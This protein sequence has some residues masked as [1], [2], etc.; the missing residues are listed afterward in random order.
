M[1]GDLIDEVSIATVFPASPEVANLYQAHVGDPSAKTDSKHDGASGQVYTWRWALGRRQKALYG[2]VVRKRPTFVAWP[3]LPAILRLVGEL[4]APDEL[5]DIGVISNDAYRIASVL[6]G[7]SEPLSTSAIRQKA[8]F[9]TGKESSQAYHNGLAELESRLVVTS[10]FSP[11]DELGIKHHALMFQRHRG[12]VDAAHAMT[13]EHGVD[14]LLRAYLPA[15]RYLL[16]PVF[17][18]HVRVPESEVVAGLLRLQETGYVQPSPYP[19][20]NAVCF[21]IAD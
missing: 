8:G 19:V 1:A 16:P 17:S 9:P 14:T 18:R 15:A 6:D 4:R 11:S 2:A 10:E 7:E 12:A 21:V 3:L 13:L 5:F 20:G